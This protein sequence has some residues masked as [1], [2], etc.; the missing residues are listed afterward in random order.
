MAPV[1]VVN[2]NKIIAGSL[3]FVKMKY[4]HDLLHFL[5]VDVIATLDGSF[6]LGCLAGVV[7]MDASLGSAV[8]F[9]P[10]PAR[11]PEKHNRNLVEQVNDQDEDNNELPHKPKNRVSKVEVS[12]VTGLNPH[13]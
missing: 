1:P 7:D 8:E 11:C 10:R 13:F 2:Q 9:L 4:A 5:V 12:T 6:S 3:V